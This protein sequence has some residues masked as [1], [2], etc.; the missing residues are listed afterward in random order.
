MSVAMPVVTVNVD[1]KQGTTIQSGLPRGHG[2]RAP[3]FASVQALP[4]HKT[5]TSVGQK[6]LTSHC[7]STAGEVA[8]PHSMANTVRNSILF[9]LDLP[10]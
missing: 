3:L 9:V 2:D 4:W 10:S 6:W 5:N 7:M 8:L 1:G